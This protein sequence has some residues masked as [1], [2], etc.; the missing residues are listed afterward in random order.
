MDPRNARLLAV[1]DDPFIV[2]ILEEGLELSGYEVETASCADEAR[3]V[4]TSGPAFEV[5][6]C[7][8]DMPG[9]SGRELLAW[10]KRVDPD[11]A[12][13]MV[14]GISEA[15]VAVECMHRGAYDY[16]VKPFDLTEVRA[17]V[18]Q[19]IEKRSLVIENRRYQNHLQHLV[20]ERTSEVVEAMERIRGLNEDLRTAYDATLTTLMIALDYRDFETQGHSIRVVDYAEHLAKR[21][22]IEEPEL[23]DLRRGTM[24]HD[25]GKIGIPDAILRKPGPLEEM[26]WEI[27]RMHP[28][29]GYRMLE[30]IEFLSVP[31]EIVLTHQERWDG[32]GYPKGLSG[33]EI[34]LGARIFAVADAFDAMTTD[35]P[36]RKALRYETARQEVI[37]FCGIHFDPRVVEAFLSVEPATWNRLRERADELLASRVR[38]GIPLDLFERISTT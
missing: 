36:Y 30:D 13:I 38:H 7:D 21:L 32:S 35:R 19:A 17:R 16:V 26:E 14:T 27:M 3:R 25:V 2:E 28:E 20:E 9:E 15:R 6:L 4:F 10:L 24:L 37:D 5:V 11:V 34:P 18:T 22:G 1:D 23:T 8:I 29:I 33:E 31:A 12:V